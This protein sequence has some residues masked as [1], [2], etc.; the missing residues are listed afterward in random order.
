[1]LYYIFFMKIFW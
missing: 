1:M